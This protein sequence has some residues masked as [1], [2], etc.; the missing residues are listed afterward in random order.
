MNPLLID[1]KDMLETEINSLYPLNLGDNL[2]ISVMPDS[3]IDCV[4]LY[5][6]SSSPSEMTMDDTP[7]SEIKNGGFQVLIRNTNW[8]TCYSIAQAVE[9]VLQ[10]KANELWNNTY[11]LF[12]QKLSG[13]MQLTQEIPKKR[14]HILS[15]NFI[16]K[17]SKKN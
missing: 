8:L 12:I 13:P 2:H 10:G 1:I 15:L 11:Y 9:D 6:T 5:D 4:A 3:P 7:A 17:R 16:V 14:Q